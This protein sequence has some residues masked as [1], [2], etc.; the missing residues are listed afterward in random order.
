MTYKQIRL[1]LGDQLNAHHSWYQTLNS[2]TLY[3]IA[4]LKQETGYVRHHIQKV[5]AFFAAMEQFATALTKAGHAVDYLTLDDTQNFADLPELIGHLCQR[6]QC[7]VFEYQQ[8][9]EHRLALQL[10]N[11][12]STLEVDVNCFDTE[13][14]LLPFSEITHYFSAGKHHRL[15]AF[16]RKMR[17]RFNIL[18]TPNGEP[19]GEQWNFD[20]ENRQALK[21]KDLDNIP[22]PLCFSTDINTIIQRLDRHQVNYIGY[23]TEQLLW[24]TTRKQA[25]E[26]LHYFCRYQLPNFG[27]FQDA[28]TDQSI[29]AWS[30]YHSRLSFA[31]N[32]KI[33][34]PLGVIQT[35]IE[36]YEQ[37]DGA[38]N[39][40]QIEGFVRQIL[41]WRE[42]VR[43]MYWANGEA[44]SQLNHLEATAALPSWYWTGETKM[45]CLHLSLIHI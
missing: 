15:E 13:H 36:A 35:A 43:G 19:S 39:L 16:Y 33:L 14:F 44:Y 22:S 12:K 27:R 20:Q 25:T 10:A 3:V 45:N 21:S 31:L 41:G 1:I 23:T 7:E 2:D 42:Y 6:Y 9:D 5:C 18:M 37:S 30:L 29:D 17:K 32:S 34:N 24:P 40:A 28:M 38:I 11:L 26:L 4:E 8:P